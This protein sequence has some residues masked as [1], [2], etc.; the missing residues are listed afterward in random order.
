MFVLLNYGY[1][2]HIHYGRRHMLTAFFGGGVAGCA[3]QFSLY[4]YQKVQWENILPSPKTWKM[5]G[6]TFVSHLHNWQ[7]RALSNVFSHVN[8][9]RPC[10]GCSAALS[11]LMAVESCY[12]IF[13]LAQKIRQPMPVFDWE[14]MY[15][16]SQLLFTSLVVYEDFRMLLGTTAKDKGFL[17]SLVAYSVDGVGHAAHVGGFI[18]GL[19]Y[20]ALVLY[21]KKRSNIEIKGKDK[22]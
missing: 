20:F 15:Q 16:M 14:V 21:G 19:L 17:G 4:L 7:R 11:S 1:N 13:S 12:N 18:F 8:A 22:P 3:A 6:D 5:F 10:V 2:V 9:W